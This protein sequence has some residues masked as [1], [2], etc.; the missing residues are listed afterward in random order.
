MQRSVIGSFV[1]TRNE[2]EIC[3]DLA[4]RGRIVPLVYKTFPLGEAREAMAT[5]ERRENFGKIVLKP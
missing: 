5:L 3:L 1:Y 2:V 4:R